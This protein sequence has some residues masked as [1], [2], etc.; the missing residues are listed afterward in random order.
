MKTSEM[1]AMLEESPNLKFDNGTVIFGAREIDGNIR[2]W[3]YSTN[4]LGYIE[5]I[6]GDYCCDWK[7]LSAESEIRK[8]LINKNQ[9]MDRTDFQKFLLRGTWYIE[10]SPNES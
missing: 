10:D 9:G 6:A 2:L 7:L 4:A 3:S 8:T 1:I 5:L